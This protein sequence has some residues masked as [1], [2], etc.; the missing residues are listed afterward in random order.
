MASIT[1]RRNKDG[2]IIS[3]TI[4]VYR[5]YNISG[6]RLKPYLMTW[7]P[8]DKMTDKQIQ[9][10]LQWQ[11]LEFE[12]R[13]ENGEA[14]GS[15]I[16]LCDFCDKYLEM[17]KTFLS[18]ATYEL[19]KRNITEY[20]KPALGHIKVKD[21]KPMHIQQ[22]LQR[23]AELPKQSK[24]AEEED[25]DEKISVSTVKR[26]L[27][28]LQSVLKQAVKLGIIPDSPAKAEKLTLP[29]IVQPKV[30]IFTKQET[31]KML[32]ALE[33][34]PLQY[35]VLLQLALYMGARR[36]ELVA[37]KFSD[38][39]FNTNKITIERSAFKLSGQKMQ[40]KPPK[41]NET[42]CITVSTACISLIEELKREKEREAY[43]IGTQWHEGG[44][45]FT[46]WNG[47]IINISTPS[48]WFNDFL[49]R[50]GLP[51]RKF[52][53]LRH[54]SATLLLYGGVNVRQVQSRLGHGNIKTTNI[55]LHCVEETDAE[56]A[57]VL[58]SILDTKKKADTENQS[59]LIIKA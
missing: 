27:A 30:S 36:G 38:I 31:V 4:R 7:K 23:L 37:L 33:N 28:V 40:F 2:K 29:K 34:E 25:P 22:Y 45:L 17:A 39:D 54:T 15:N 42:R 57:T 8:D 32:Y 58:E 19:Y 47:E 12:K 48:H 6:R 9:K 14:S 11:A 5:G 56:A 50:N 41:D 35:Q 26:Y 46:Q 43:R 18:P 52:H 1:P 53:A 24:R 10:E 3:Y 20:V 59:S 21:I 13:C 49:K 16:K 55:Y 51:H 44:W